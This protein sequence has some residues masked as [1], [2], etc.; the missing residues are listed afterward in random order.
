MVK[1]ILDH[2]DLFKTDYKYNNISSNYYPVDSAIMTRDT[3]SNRIQVT[4]MNDRAQGGSAGVSGNGTIELM[5]QRRTTEDDN[6]G[7][8]E[9]LNETDFN[10]DGL[11][12]TATY[13][14]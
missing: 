12:V 1:R 13:N 10:G 14:M 5:Q 2:R 3:N 11:K 4:I 8:N 6:K 9:P 7:V